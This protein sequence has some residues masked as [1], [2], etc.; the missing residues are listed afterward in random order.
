MTMKP[1]FEM[2]TSLESKPS[3]KDSLWRYVPI[4]AV[5]QSITKSCHGGG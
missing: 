5:Q 2:M 3:K 1:R 4:P